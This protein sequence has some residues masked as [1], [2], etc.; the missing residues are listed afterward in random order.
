MGTEA[1]LILDTTRLQ[2]EIRARGFSTAQEFADSVGVHRNTVGNYLS[3]KTALPSAL[4]RILLALDLA[5]ADVLSLPVRR[6]QVPGLVLADL[7]EQ[8]HGAAPDVA[9]VLFGSRAR[10]TAKRYSDYD[11]GVFGLDAFGFATFSQFLDLA[12]AWNEASLSTV[13]LVDL[14]HADAGFLTS[15]SEDLV[16]LAGFHAAWCALLHK[17]GMH[18]YE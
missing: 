16:F 11:V 12:S 1:Q 13:Q 9:V 10:G 5:P 7:I 8:L 4:A 18:L 2:H 3:G 6:R 17:A 15:L 14:T